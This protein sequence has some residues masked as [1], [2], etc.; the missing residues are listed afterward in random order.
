MTSTKGR[1]N[2]SWAA[3]S[4][5]NEDEFCAVCKHCGLTELERWL[6]DDEGRAV[7]GLVWLRP[8]GSTAAIRP[9]AYSKNRRPKVLPRSSWQDQYRGVPIGGTPECPKSPDSW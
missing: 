5:P 4:R 8:N 9:F 2:H 3:G 6:L 7:V 1:S